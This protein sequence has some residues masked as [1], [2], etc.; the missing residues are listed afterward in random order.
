MARALSL[1]VKD[2]A[3]ETGCALRTAQLHA[4][5]KDPRWTEYLAARGASTPGP[6]TP[7]EQSQPSN[8]MEARVRERA[9]MHQLVKTEVV[10]YLAAGDI[11]M[12]VTLSRREEELDAAWRAATKDWLDFE[13]R[14]GRLV[15]RDHHTNK[16]L[17]ALAS[18]AAVVRNMANELGPRL[19][20][21]SPTEGIATVREWQATRL[22]PQFAAARA[23]ITGPITEQN[24]VTPPSNE[25]RGA[26]E[27][28]TIPRVSSTD[29][30]I[31]A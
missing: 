2:Y 18:I 3:R 13:K 31:H 11:T 16:A 14:A 19:M 4:K 1:I 8:E 5:L 15:E 21:F 27:E 7:C 10:R 24:A 22:D 30:V 28:I 25:K 12:F 6:A 26:W 23:A 9:E 17:R 29:P 20:P